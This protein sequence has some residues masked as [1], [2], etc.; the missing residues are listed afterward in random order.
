MIWTH[1]ENTLQCPVVRMFDK[2]YDIVYGTIF[3]ENRRFCDRHVEAKENG[4]I[5]AH[6]DCMGRAIIMQWSPFITTL[7]VSG[8]LKVVPG[9]LETCF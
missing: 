5:S 4:R 1:S 7:V 9:P 3:F 2:K 6:R 8:R